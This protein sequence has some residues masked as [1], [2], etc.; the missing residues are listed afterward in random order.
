MGFLGFVNA[1][2][3]QLVNELFEFTLEPFKGNCGFWRDSFVRGD[4]EFLIA[5]NSRQ[6]G[7]DRVFV[8]P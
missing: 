5:K 2:L 1:M 7:G 3:N 6:G 4:R 8:F